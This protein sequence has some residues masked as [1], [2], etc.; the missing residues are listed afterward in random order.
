M[1]VEGAFVPPV[2][3]LSNPSQNGDIWKHLTHCAFSVP[4]HRALSVS[5]VREKAAAGGTSVD[6]VNDRLAHT[7][8]LRG[9]NKKHAS[10]NGMRVQDLRSIGRII[11]IEGRGICARRV[12]AWCRRI[13]V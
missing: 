5:R 12:V 10:A 3:L 8:C 6:G 7:L 11:G 2:G 1:L 4:G 9:G 13:I